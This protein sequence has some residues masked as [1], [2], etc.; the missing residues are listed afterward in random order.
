MKSKFTFRQRNNS[1]HFWPMFGLLFERLAKKFVRRASNNATTFKSMNRRRNGGS[2]LTRQS[3]MVLA[4]FELLLL[5]SFAVVSRQRSIAAMQRI[6]AAEGRARAAGRDFQQ[7]SQH[8]PLLHVHAIGASL[9]LL[10]ALIGRHT[11]RAPRTSLAFLSC[12][13]HSVW[14]IFLII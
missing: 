2:L 8:K 6:D 12:L 5:V 4:L 1:V 11:T 3:L 10:A 13:T 7:V 9:V 14:S